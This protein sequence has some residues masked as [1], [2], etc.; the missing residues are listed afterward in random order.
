MASPFGSET[1]TVAEVSVEGGE[2]RIH[3]L[4][5]AFDPAAS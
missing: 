5:I 2:A 1:A 3:N 4:W